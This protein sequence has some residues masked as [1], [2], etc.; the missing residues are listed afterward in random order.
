MIEFIMPSGTEELTAEQLQGFITQHQ[1]EVD[2][3]YKLLFD[4]YDNEAPILRQAPK[5]GY[6]PDNRLTVN[7]AK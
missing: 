6:K 3:R 7:F 5:E 1:A 4:L 2:S